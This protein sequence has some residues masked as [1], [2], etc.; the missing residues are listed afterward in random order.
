V[1]QEYGIVVAYIQGGSE[2]DAKGGSYLYLGQDFADDGTDDR[3]IFD[4]VVYDE[5]FW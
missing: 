1:E 2:C 5:W 4:Q 3:Y